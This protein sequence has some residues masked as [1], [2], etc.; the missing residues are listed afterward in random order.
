MKFFTA[1]TLA[2]TV[3]IFERHSI[4]S[5]AASTIQPLY[6]EMAYAASGLCD[7]I[8]DQ[9][10]CTSTDLYDPLRSCHWI[11]SE[12]KC[13]LVEEED[14]CEHITDSKDTCNESSGCAW[15]DPES[16][17]RPGEGHCVSNK[18]VSEGN[19]AFNYNDRLYVV[20]SKDKCNDIKGCSWHKVDGESK[21]CHVAPSQLT[22]EGFENK[23]TCKKNGC[24]WKNKGKVCGGRWERA[25]LDFLVGKKADA[26]TTAI[27]VEYGESYVVHVEAPKAHVSERITL[28]V[29]E[30][31]VVVKT[32]LFG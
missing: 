20:N 13:V 25:F 1:T 17:G 18:I 4:Q 31:G 30:V 24:G 10:E 7:S 15:V 8:Q 23:A 16:Y 12:G 29:D 11:S 5:Q 19:C 14:I 21:K 3:L 26:A 27:R 28:V 22:C 9:D 6:S 32:P 2:S